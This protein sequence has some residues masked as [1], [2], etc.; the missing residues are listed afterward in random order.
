LCCPPLKLWGSHPPSP[1]DGTTGMRPAVLPLLRKLY[2]NFLPR[3]AQLHFLLFVFR[4]SCAII[5]QKLGPAPEL[6]PRL[7]QPKLRTVPDVQKYGTILRLHWTP[8][9][10]DFASMYLVRQ[11]GCATSGTPPGTSCIHDFSIPGAG[12]SMGIA[13]SLQYEVSATGRHNRAD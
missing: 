2:H 8:G 12:S 13:Q 11:Y 10:R 1:A 7:C 9:T 3:T 6:S 5:A 4:I